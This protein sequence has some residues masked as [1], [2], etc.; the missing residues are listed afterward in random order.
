MMININSSVIADNILPT[1]FHRAT[2]SKALQHTD[3]MVKFVA[4][5]FLNLVFGKF[6]A[7]LSEMAETR[8]I[9]VGANASDSVV[10][11]KWTKCESTLTEEI[12]RRLPEV[13]ILFALQKSASSKEVEDDDEQLA[14]LLQLFGNYQKHYPECLIESRFD[15]GKL[16]ASPLKDM[17]SD[18]SISVIG[19]L[20]RTVEFKWWTRPGTCLYLMREGNTGLSHLGNIL[21]CYCASSSAP[22]VKNATLKLMEKL[23]AETF[24]FKFHSEEVS[25]WI[26]SLR[27]CKSE[28]AILWLDNLLTGL[29]TEPVKSIQFLGKAYGMCVLSPEKKL[30]YE[31]LIKTRMWGLDA[32]ISRPSFESF[33]YSDA[34][35]LAMS[36]FS[37]AILFGI[38]RVLK[39]DEADIASFVSM[40]VS[41]VMRETQGC[42]GHISDILRIS[43]KG[44]SDEMEIDGDLG[45]KLVR[46]G[47]WG[48]R[49]YLG[50]VA[51]SV[52]GDVMKSL[53]KEK[54]AEGLTI[55]DVNR[56]LHEMLKTRQ[57]EVERFMLCRHTGL[58]SIFLIYDGIKEMES[59]V[60]EF[61]AKLPAS[62]LLENW[63]V[64]IKSSKELRDDVVV[65]EL[66]VESITLGNAYA[67]GSHILQV[68]AD[69][70]DEDFA[71]DLMKIVMQVLAIG[72]DALYV[73]FKEFLFGHP[74]LKDLCDS[75][76]RYVS[77]LATL[78]N[79]AREIEV[80]FEVES[81]NGDCWKSYVN[82]ALQAVVSGLE[83]SDAPPVELFL[84]FRELFSEE[85][86]ERIMGST[87]GS[88]EGS[89]RY[90]MLNYLLAMPS[91]QV[92][93]E[94]FQKIVFAARKDLSSTALQG[95]ILD[96]LR[97]N[98]FDCES[99][100][101]FV[102]VL[103]SSFAELLMGCGSDCC[104]VIVSLLCKVNSAYR[105]CTIEWVSKN[106]VSDDAS[107]VVI[108]H[109]LDGL[110]HGYSFES[111]P[112][113]VELLSNCGKST[114]KVIKMMSDRL[115]Q[116]PSLLTLIFEEKVPECTASVL[117]RSIAIHQTVFVDE[118]SMTEL[119]YMLAL[120]D[121]SNAFGVCRALN[122]YFH[123][124][125]K[126]FGDDA[127]VSNFTKIALSVFSL[128]FNTFK[129]LPNS[130]AADHFANV[131][132][133][134]ELGT[135]VE[136]MRVFLSKEVMGGLG[137]ESRDHVKR[138]IIA[139]LKNRLL[140]PRA[141]GLLTD[142]LKICQKVRFIF[143]T[144]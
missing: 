32:A 22:K 33:N 61:L 40:V 82:N 52:A 102:S 45:K 81:G 129:K 103:D 124:I 18:V 101:D 4:I 127:V 140:D 26:E 77:T 105:E 7:C 106:G 70:A 86:L 138:F 111:S 10:A 9:A 24:I 60:S 39:S 64:G 1:C 96:I 15:C 132:V 117:N 17:K 104:A 8:K 143:L 12:W 88:L 79:H 73:K 42:R 84:Q 71:V 72:D 134:I 114:K 29:I 37:P 67:F 130:L 34:D 56:D 65:R 68:M 11:M 125:S 6:E 118:N 57:D 123:V 3:E 122:D 35:E 44:D 27:S 107:V 141:M 53:P 14:T 55:Y 98:I 31:H 112:E 41:R 110:F 63:L 75:D 91:I 46:N 19:L 136:K 76:N 69:V 139:T 89:G 113:A 92:N 38:Q 133:E 135:L 109:L 2:L 54:K 80:K 78:I 85:D 97:K 47:E 51:L 58:G 21:E 90:V 30:V 131:D 23:L 49:D 36:P 87:L 93:Q 108:S 50:C 83:G 25:I 94:G 28:K 66:L 119:N 95:A 99:R 100:L 59:D 120:K 142:V 48:V 62:F 5:T 16:L 126:S 115:H 13:Q 20:Y 144:F 116:Y 121:P 137:V 43:L 74:S 128:V